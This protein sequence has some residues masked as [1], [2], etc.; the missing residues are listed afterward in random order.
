[1]K[2]FSLN[3]SRK[4]ALL[5][6]LTL[7]CAALPLALAEEGV[8]APDESAATATELPEPEM[9]TL[10]G[11]VLEV[12]ED[13]LLLHTSGGVQVQA[14]LF[15]DTLYST[16][17]DVKPGDYVE[18]GYSGIMTYS[19]PGQIAAMAVT[20]YQVS[21]TVGEI[22]EEGFLLTDADGAQWMVHVPEEAAIVLAEGMDIT[23]YFNGMTT[24]SLPPQI[25]A[26]HLRGN[27]ISGTA[28]AVEEGSFLLTDENGE[29]QIIHF[30][31][32]TAV[33]TTLKEGAKVIVVTS[34][35]TAPSLPAQY[36]AQEILPDA[37][38]DAEA[39]ATETIID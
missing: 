39:T 8:T 36:F 38:E 4:L 32:T 18:I 17:G 16:D 31:E 9:V 25:N 11:I 13:Y 22:S 33:C 12:T 34:G 2:K 14:N 3:L 7:L 20:C 30:D 24:R 5:L 29:E 21:G 6:A 19:L 27:T 15:D 23:V 10:G 28:S 35:I 37:A 26:L 1:M